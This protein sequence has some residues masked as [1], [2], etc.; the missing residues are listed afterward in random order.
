MAHTDLKLTL[1]KGAELKSASQ[2]GVKEALESIA[3][4]LN[5]IALCLLNSETAFDYGGASHGAL[6]LLYVLDD[7]LQFDA[8]RRDR[9]KAGTVL[10]S[11]YGNR[12]L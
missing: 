3:E 9:L 12:D 4:V 1:G 7:G 5:T 2:S 11:D 8:G 10:P 6:S